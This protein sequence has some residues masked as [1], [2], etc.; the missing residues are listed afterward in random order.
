[1]AAGSAELEIG[2]R[3]EAVLTKKKFPLDLPWVAARLVVER[4]LEHRKCQAINLCVNPNRN[5][6]VV[7][8]VKVQVPRCPAG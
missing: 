8:R 5:L 7:L 4:E 2:P 1:M 3:S 6:R